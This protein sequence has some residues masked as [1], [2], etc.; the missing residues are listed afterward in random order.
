ML[1][2]G[3]AGFSAV[4][5]GVDSF[6]VKGRIRKAEVDDLNGDLFPDMVIYIY[7]NGNDEKGT[8]VHVS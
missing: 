8:V 3:E 2:C 5:N 6:E 4:V 7:L 1:W